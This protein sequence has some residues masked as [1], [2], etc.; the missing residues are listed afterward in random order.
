MSGSGLG[1]GGVPFAGWP[2]AFR[3]PKSTTWFFGGAGS[4]ISR[5]DET[6]PVSVSPPD[7]EDQQ[8]RTLPL[9]ARPAA[10][11][12]YPPGGLTSLSGSV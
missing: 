11:S 12:G 3:S 7:M 1:T 2:G 8:R 4:G 9:G 10:D 6:V 5:L